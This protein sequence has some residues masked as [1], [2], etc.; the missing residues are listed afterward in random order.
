MKKKI[1]VKFEGA[2]TLPTLRMRDSNDKFTVLTLTSGTASFMAEVGLAY[3]LF[4]FVVGSED[5][6]YKISLVAPAK[7]KV[8][9]NRN[10]IKLKI[11]TRTAGY[12]RQSFV[13]QEE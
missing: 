4:W 7:H 6:K 9:A 12:G 13:V 8:V 2:N 10:P 5:A 11:P 3:K 1:T